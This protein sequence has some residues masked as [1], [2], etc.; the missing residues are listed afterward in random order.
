[1]QENAISKSAAI[2][3]EIRK[4]ILSCKTFHEL[5]DK[6]LCK[7]D[8]LQLTNTQATTEQQIRKIL[9]ITNEFPSYFFVIYFKS[10]SNFPKERVDQYLELKKCYK[11]NGWK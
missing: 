11:E 10:K 2:S 1:M 5:G 4:R 6:E 8:Y 3:D 7:R 9:T